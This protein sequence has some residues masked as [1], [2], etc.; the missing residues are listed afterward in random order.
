MYVATAFSTC[1]DKP[2][3]LILITEKWLSPIAKYASEVLTVPI[4]TG[5]LWD[6][7]RA[8]K[9]AEIAHLEG[10]DVARKCAAYEATY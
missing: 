7:Y 8:H 3:R 9:A 4:E 6:T 1:R 2:H 5:T 10:M